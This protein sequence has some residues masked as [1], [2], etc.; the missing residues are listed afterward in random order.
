MKARLVLITLAC[1]LRLGAETVPDEPTEDPREAAKR[2]AWNSAVLIISL[3][4]QGDNQ[5]FPGIRAWLDDFQHIAATTPPPESGKPFPPI[6]TDALLTRNP[7]FWAAYYEVQPGD[8]GLSLLHAALLLSGGEAQRASVVATLGLQRPAIPEDIKRGLNSVIAHC[9]SA[10]A[11][12]SH[13]VQIGVKLHD[14]CDFTGALKKFDAAIS[15]WPANGEAYYERGSTLRMKAIEEARRAGSAPAGDEKSEALPDPRETVDC[16]ARARRHDPLHLLAYQGNDPA[17]LSG[18]MALVRSGVG[19]WDAIRKRPEHPV[20]TSQLRDFS[21]ACQT[22]GIDDFAL[23]VR[24]L[25]VA[26]NRRYSVDDH[27]FINQSL[28][29]LAPAALTAALLTRIGGVTRVPARQIAVPTIVEPP[30]SAT[31]ATEE[32]PP[33]EVKKKEPSTTT[34][35]KGKSGKGRNST[36]TSTKSKRKSAED[37]PPKKKSSGSSKSKKRKR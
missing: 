20:K 27:D 37:S 30:E 21:E 26:S 29:H 33:K 23:V 3:L 7:N 17:M 14:L 4:E 28:E 32:A 6:D 8:P 12:S 31:A 19:V 5:A 25:V 10:Q 2:E 34:T 11:H 24:Q 35:S 16:F 13:L 18:M 1:V 9:Q 36:T 15:E 22:A